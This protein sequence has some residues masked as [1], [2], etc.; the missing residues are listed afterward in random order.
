M[1]LCSLPAAS[2]LAANVL[3]MAAC[4]CGGGGSA[5]DAGHD[6]RADVR[7][8]R[9]DT[10][11]PDRGPDLVDPTYCGGS[12]KREPVLLKRPRVS[13]P[14]PTCLLP[15]CKRLTFNQFSTAFEVKGDVLVVSALEPGEVHYV[16]LK[17]GKEWLVRK[18]TGL[19][20]CQYLDTDG[21]VIA[22]ACGAVYPGWPTPGFAEAISLYDPRTRYETDLSCFSLWWTT[23]DPCQ[24]NNLALGT[25]GV[26]VNMSLGKCRNQDAFFVSRRG[27]K[28]RNL[29]RVGGGV[30][31]AHLSGS[32]VVWHQ[33][34]RYAYQIMLYDLD[35]GKKRLL[36]PNPKHDQW[37]PRIVGDMV[38]WTDHRNAPG[39]Y[40]APG[41]TDIYG[42]DLSTG[43]TFA[44]STHPARQ[45]RPD[46]DGDWVVW[47]DW[48]HNP[49]TMTPPDNGLVQKNVDVY[50]KNLKT[51][52]ELQVTSYK[53]H[54]SFPKI[55]G[56]RVFFIRTLDVWMVS[57]PGASESAEG[58]K[59]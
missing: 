3:L 27:G 29:S 40:F 37:D 14:A 55:D 5:V 8:P 16:D 59:P 13:G 51:G 58:T 21:E 56:G 43:K 49:G 57:L 6:L 2:V 24:P 25:T 36:A 35:T 33:A 38:V 53:K 1:R 18:E 50:A 9:P 45:H 44:I 26:V 28:L 41:N 11:S 12:R 52:Q 34:A 48:R 7:A 30:H 22:Y 54:D 47:N 17:T 32:K 10:V 31:G 23:S 4:H 42:H 15:N 39:S 19:P 46:V 20:G